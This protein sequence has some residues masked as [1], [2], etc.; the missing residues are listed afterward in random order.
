MEALLRNAEDCYGAANLIRRYES[1]IDV[2]R[3]VLHAF[4]HYRTSQL[5]KLQREIKLARVNIVSAAP[6]Q[7]QRVLKK[8]ERRRIHFRVLLLRL[9]S[10]MSNHCGVMLGASSPIVDVGAIHRKTRNRLADRRSK[11]VVCE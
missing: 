3:R 10:C 1:R 2:E 11:D 7:Q 6:T 5:L 4:R 9:R 8:V